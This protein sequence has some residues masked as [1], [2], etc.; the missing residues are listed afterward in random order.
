[1]VLVITVISISARS[2]VVASIEMTIRPQSTLIRVL[3]NDNDHLPRYKRVF[4]RVTVHASC[5]RCEAAFRFVIRVT[6]L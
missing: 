5:C 4:E 1:M 6:R 2:R 3:R